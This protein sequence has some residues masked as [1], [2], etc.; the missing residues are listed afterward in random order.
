M[1][2]SDFAK[3][4]ISQL[5]GAIGTDG[6]R[7]SA[8]SATMAMSA[9]ATAITDYLIAN[10]KVTVTYAG[11]IPGTPPAPDPVVTDTFKIVGTCAPTGPSDSF[12]AWVRQIEANIISGFQLAPKGDMGVVFTAIPFSNSGIAVT[13]SMLQSAHDINDKSPQQKV[14]EI[15]CGGVMDWINTTAMN[16]TP[17]PA[18]RPTGPSTGTGSIVKIAIT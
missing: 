18:T 16:A 6:D 13:Q 3:A 7:Y 4:I 10:T 1:S 8:S 5:S 11:T 14:W 12:D 2:K 17:G 9:V 15:I